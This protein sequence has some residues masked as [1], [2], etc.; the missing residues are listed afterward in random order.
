GASEL[1]RVQSDGKTGIGTSS[2]DVLFHVGSSTPTTVTGYQ[3]AFF[4]GAVEIDGALTLDTTLTVA[5]GGTGS[6]TLTGLLKGNGTGIVQTAVAGTDYLSSVSD[7]TLATGNIY[8][9]DGSSNPT[10]TNTLYIDTNER[11]GIGTESPDSTLHVSGETFLSGTGPESLTIGRTGN[12]VT[13]KNQF[14]SG[15]STWL[16]TPS[17][18]NSWTSG[19]N[20]TTNNF[21]FKHTSTW[22]GNGTTVLSLTNAGNVGVGTSSPDVLFH[23]GS[24]TPTTVSGYQDAFFS[25][26]VEIDGALTLDTALTVANGGTGSTTLT[27]LLKGNGTGIVQTA[28]AGTDYLSGVSDLTLATGNIYIGDG[29]SNPVATNTL[30]IDTNERI[31]IGTESPS[32]KLHLYGTGQA[33][34]RSETA[35]GRIMTFGASDSGFYT[36]IGTLSSHALLL[37]TQN[38]RNAYILDGGMNLGKTFA[39][40]V[41]L[42]NTLNVEG[43]IG[44][45]TLGPDRK[46]DVLDASNPQLRLTHTNE[47]V[48]T[49][50]QTDSSG[51]LNIIPTGD[52]ISILSAEAPG[53]TIQIGDTA[54]TYTA[55]PSLRLKGASNWSDILVGSGVSS[56]VAS[57][58]WVFYTDNTNESMRILANGNVGIGTS[59]PDVL[60]HVGSSTPTTVTG[61]QDAFFSGAVEIDGAL[62]LDTALTVANGGTGS[63]TLTGLLKG[64]GTGIVQTAVAGTDYLSGVS[65]LTLATGNIY[66]G[67]GSNNPTATNTLYIDTNSYVG[68]GT[69]SPSGVFDV[70]DGVYKHYSN[71]AYLEFIS[72]SGSAAK[73]IRMTPNSGTPGTT[74]GAT[75][76]VTESGG[77]TT[78]KFGDKDSLAY[79]NLITGGTGVGNFG[80]GTTSPMSKLAIADT[81]TQL[82][83]AYGTATSTHFSTDINGELTI[84]PSGS[85]VIF[86]Q[87]SATNPGVAFGDGDSG[88]YEVADDDIAFSSSGSIVFRANSSGW[89]S[90]GNFPYIKRSGNSTTDPSIAPMFNDANTGISRSSA[91]QLSLIS[92]GIE[93]LRMVEDTTDYSFFPSGTTLG[94]GTSSP[95]V[96][97]HVGSSTPGT[98]SGYRDAYFSNDV[99]IDGALYLGTALDETQGGTGQTTYTTGDI[100]YASGANTLT[101]LGVG[102]DNQVLKLSGGVPTWGSDSTGSA[103]SGFFATTSDSLAIYPVD[104]TDV[105]MLGSDATSTAEIVLDQAGNSWIA[106]AYNFGIGTS[107]PDVLFHVGSST[108]TTV[109]GYQDAFFSG[110]VE[111]DGALTLDTTLTVANGGTGSTTL[112]GLLK[113]NG[114]GMIQTAVAGTDYLSSV[115]DLTLTAGNIYVGDGSN[116]PIATSVLYIDTNSFVGI[117]TES[118]TAM[119]SINSSGSNA[120]INNPTSGQGVILS[121]AGGAT[122]GEL[123]VVANSSAWA[124]NTS[125]AYFQ[126][127]TL[128]NNNATFMGGTYGADAPLDRL[129]FNSEY[130]TIT[131]N[132]YTDTPVATAIFEVV[133]DTSA[134]DIFQVIGAGSQS[135][136]YLQIT[137]NGSSAGNL[138]AVNNSGYLGVGTSSP[139]VLFHVGSSTPTTVSGYQDAFFSGAVEIDGALTLDTA[140]TVANGGTGSTTLTGLLKGNGTG[141]VQTAVAGTDYLSGLSDMALA[142]GNIYVGNDSNN[143]AATD[144]LYI[145]SDDRVGIGTT[146]PS[147]KLQVMG[148]INAAPETNA[149]GTSNVYTSLVLGNLSGANAGNGGLFAGA[150]YDKS[151]EPFS[152]LSVWDSG[153]NRILYFGGGG[154]NAPDAMQ[155]NF[156]TAGAYS[157]ANNAGT[158]TMTM[159]ASNVGIG[160]SNPLHKLSVTTTDSQYYI[161]GTNSSGVSSGLFQGPNIA[162]MGVSTNHPLG[163]FTNNSA[164]SMVLD[165]TG[166][167]ILSADASN[168]TAGRRFE[169]VDAS[170]PQIRLSHTNGSVYTDFQTDSSGYLTIDSSGNTVSIA[171]G[172]YLGVGTSS[173]DVLFHVG[174]STPTTVSGYQDAFFSND[175]EIDG[176]LFIDGTGT[177]TNAGDFDIAGDLEVG[178]SFYVTSAG[179]VTKGTWQGSEIADAYI[180]DSLTVTGYMQDE[181]INTFSELQSWVSD[182]TIVDTTQI[183]TLAEL[184]AIMGETIASTTWAG[185]TSLVTLGTVTTGTWQGNVIDHERGGLE[186]DVSSYS[187][188]LSITGGSTAQV[189][190]AA[191]LNALLSGETL[192]S[193]THVWDMSDYTNFSVSATGLE[194]SDDALAW[195]TGYEGLRTAS[196]TNWNTFYDTPSNRITAGDNISWTGNTLNVAGTSQLTDLGYVL[197]PADSSGQE[198]LLLGGTSSST[199]EI[200]L[201]FGGNSW[202]ANAYNFGIGTS[203]P[204]VLF[205][206]GSSTP[207]TVSGY[208]DA[209][210]SGA[211]EIDGAL[212]LDTTL[213]VANGG[214]GSTTLSGLLKG[215]GTGIVQTAVAG[216][217]YLSGLSD[218][219]LA[220]GNIYVGDGSS[221]PV[222]TNTL[223]IDTNERVGIGTTTPSEKLTLTDGNILLNISSSTSPVETKGYTNS[224]LSGPYDVHVSGNYAYVANYSNNRLAIFDVSDPDSISAEGYIDT[225]LNGPSGVYVSGNYAYVSSYGNNRLAIFDI[226]NPDSII[227]RGYTD[228]NLSGPMSVYVSGNYAYVSSYGNNRLAIFDISNPDS[229][230]AK[231]YTDTNLNDPFSLDISGNYAYVVS[232]GNSRLAIFDISNPDSIIARG[233]TD[234]NLSGAREVQV[235]DNYAY[236][237]SANNN[238]LA[239]F[240]VSNPDSI[241][242]KDYTDDNLNSPQ[243]IN[244]AGNYA[245]ITSYSN[246]R[247]A[248][249]DISDPDAIATKGYV[250]TNLNAPRKSM[251]VGNYIYVANYGNSRLAIF[252]I[253]HL[254]IPAMYAGAIRTSELRVDNNLQIGGELY[255][256]NGLS[257]G[258]GG[259][260][261]GGSGGIYAST[262]ESAALTVTQSLT[263]DILNIFDGTREALTILDGGN[264]GIGTSS[265][266]VLLHVGSSTPTTVSGY[267]DAFFSNDVEIGNDLYLT[268]LGTAAG[269]FIAVDASGKV[270][271]TTTPSGSGW[272][273]LSDMTLATGNVYMGDGSN[274]PIATSVLY[275]DTSGYV[276]I[277]TTSPDASLHLGNTGAI[278]DGLVFGDGDSGLY[279]KNDDNLYFS[280]AGTDIVNIGA[281]WIIYGADSGTR[282]GIVN[283]NPSD[284]N[285]VLTFSDDANTGVGRNS[286]DQLSMIAGGVEMLRMVEGATE[287]SYFPSGTTLGVGTSSPDVLFHVGSSTPG[288]VSGYRD[289]FFSGNVEIDGELYLGTALD[290]TQGGTGQTTYTEGD[291]LYASGA[292][293]LSKLAK[294]DD[295]EVLTL[296]SGVPSWASG[297]SGQFTDLGYVLHPSDSSGQEALLLGGTSSSTAEIVLDFGGNSWITGGYLGIG[298]TSPQAALHIGTASTSSLTSYSDDVMIS[299]DIEIDGNV[300]AGALEFGTNAGAVSW[301]DMPITSAASVG[302][303]ESYTAEIDDTSIL[304]IYAESDGSGGIQS[305][306]VGIATTTPWSKLAVYGDIFIEGT[307]RYL[308]FGT[309]TSSGGYGFRDNGGTLEFKSSGESWAEIGA[310]GGEFT[311]LGYVIH[312]TDVSGQEALLLGGTSS[313]TAEIAF[314]FGGNSWIANDYY[315]GVG[316]SSPLYTLDVAASSTASYLSR[317]YN[318]STA[319][320]SGGLLVRSDGDGSLLTLN[321]DGS[322]I[323]DITPI[324]STF[325]NPVAMTSA[326]DVSVAYDLIMTNSTAG[327]IK[328]DGPGYIKTDSSWQNL[329]LTLEAAG[330]GQVIM[331]GSSSAAAASSYVARIENTS[332][333]TTADGLYIYIEG[334]GTNDTDNSY[335]GFGNK[336]DSTA[337]YIYGNGDTGVTYGTTGGD[338]A[339]Y[340]YTTDTDLDAGEVVCVD[341]TNANTVKRCSRIADSNVMGIVSTAPGFLGMDDDYKRNN[342]NYKMVAMVGQIPTK[343]SNEN[344]TVRPGDSLTSASIAGYVMKANPGDPTVGI[345]LEGFG[346]ETVVSNEGASST[347]E[348]LAQA[349]L[350][351][352]NVLIS[353]RNKSL[354]VEMV[355]SRITERVANMEIEDEVQIMIEN[356]VDTIEFDEEVNEII[357]GEIAKFDEG[358]SVELDEF[359]G[360]LSLVAASV[361]DLRASVLDIDTRVTALEEAENNYNFEMDEDGNIKIGKNAT[362][363]NPTVAVVEIT[364]EEEV[365]KTAFIINQLANEDVADFKYR[366]VSIMNIKETGKVSIIGELT[367]DGRIMACSGGSCGE[368]LELAVDETMGDIGVEGKVV[369]GA[370]EGYCDEGFVWVAG[371]SE[372]GTMP[373][374]C[375]MENKMRNEYG[376]LWT[377]I[378]QGEAQVTCQ[379]LG[380]GY[381]LIRESEWMTI[382]SDVITN[383]VNDIDNEIAG[384]QLATS[385]NQT[386]SS[387]LS[388][389]LNNGNV[390]YD[391][392]GETGEWTNKVTTKA[393]N[394]KPASN[395]W[396]EYMEVADYKSYNI[397]PPYYLDSLN[398]IGKIKTG[399]NENNLRG[400]IRGINGIFGLDLS[401]SPT[402]ATAT[403]GFRCAK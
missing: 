35:A 65:D 142:T 33:L 331:T 64:N 117:G 56:L 107:S 377:E 386:A 399:D 36:H 393:G 160:D 224:N 22:F 80:I 332:A 177:S 340:Y 380:D 302:T 74:Q 53:R 260:L 11:V 188:L 205:H 104:T 14:S 207:T 91:D 130:T 119:L 215:N 161:K 355:E 4:S 282:G 192:A 320:T 391:M 94:V 251:I 362:S 365:A 326:G 135:G 42:E 92:G 112:T 210:F 186:A 324:Q 154:W 144:T 67:D 195:S 7:L 363:T 360:E 138:L 47:S 374:F 344:G 17:S 350:G 198:A 230:V 220:T 225:N 289:A 294:G 109:S 373:G 222:A 164:Y 51:D 44:V 211:V 140:L 58:Q 354:T 337:G 197:H 258:P 10:A 55:Y 155:L 25:G 273:A 254:N 262:T 343:V 158:L 237:A 60:F 264:V 77:I 336:D 1:F 98:V 329:D 376:D 102:S 349:E 12:V 366:D 274:N 248:I 240:D 126:I 263:G 229:I 300:Y 156:Y 121:A 141:I 242:A 342:P 216:T 15:H 185:A 238:R 292:N 288:T 236:V 301:I 37:V 388:Y 284:T 118:P 196:S 191:E 371:S 272:S 214:T 299:G 23:V 68:I 233:Y 333:S 200:A 256:E 318:H 20:V 153:S 395:D 54:Q 265:P 97:F 2:P 29:S 171:S 226:S 378:S 168:H 128:A 27:G 152:A 361:D 8:V 39:N 174:S 165:V 402:M 143:P 139:D 167:L 341:V 159:K 81:G 277:G 59:S 246:N 247:L 252:E 123:R 316:T 28:V 389:V 13:L 221:N 228:T 250:E 305:Y 19:V 315:F 385:T 243:G 5:N 34:L 381:H 182:A 181:D 351:E 392:S 79:A 166:D 347:E 322:D 206:V 352:I 290:E 311:D 62:T 293:T 244:I 162:G 269:T 63:T 125:T 24:S 364:A 113:G 276:G 345:A 268:T 87:G 148:A 400:F 111:I 328:F 335:I 120:T 317:I 356:A 193:T 204:D 379:N 325:N 175:V 49:D 295:G 314:D 134:R 370:F 190:S 330:L 245:Y 223:Y 234:T 90:T 304:T 40:S 69:E 99:E 57:H 279:E 71:G 50:F 267:R 150:R 96:L 261:S 73:R 353:R 115:S 319:S 89:Q 147:G 127:R 348:I 88:W 235:V 375:V 149:F 368:E 199:A 384:L 48:Y 287:Y 227:A 110:A 21:D 46:L 38:A 218:M 307:D 183:D 3:D 169:V 137:S 359:S 194:E 257:I 187:G 401:N 100:L 32:N 170:N 270:I 145:A 298:T 323:V 338:Y 309:A 82:T 43:S 157:E 202:I 146:T 72:T 101:K 219:A 275:I 321:N 75:M 253:P 278:T 132:S 313:S 358:L 184:N 176:E 259:F 16:Y 116:N 203:S 306:G 312:P 114:T 179:T 41:A 6:T 93:M 396:I 334:D 390:V 129:Q 357:E 281:N 189:D 78:L 83:L 173:P 52:N 286:S 70:R 95:D 382:A 86:P 105:F 217:D 310:G 209:F 30:Y 108:P 280:V 172:D 18:G 66:I 106:N 212:T 369:A 308:N 387:S 85:S 285:P 103:G 403:V 151:T 208:R 327:G 266:D 346:N 241:T 9:G 303:V 339:E 232:N 201:D 231:G 249:F 397:I 122:T 239:I 271:A 372:Y 297:G 61:Y 180:S 26:A 84:T 76:F 163:F 136:D 283:E 291:I 213:T 31:G 131:N 296:A 383:K 133:N 178:S 45:G 394:I 398:G 367:V 124:D 255:V